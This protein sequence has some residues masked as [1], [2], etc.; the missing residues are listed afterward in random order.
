[1]SK[2]LKVVIGRYPNAVPKSELAE[3]CGH[4]P[5]SGGFANYLGKLRTLGTIDYRDGG[6][7]ALPV[8]FL[9]EDA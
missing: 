9:E 1:M 2:I 7:V 8:L 6:V 4:S 3:E 5:T